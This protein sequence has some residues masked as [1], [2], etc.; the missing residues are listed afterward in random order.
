MPCYQGTVQFAFINHKA[1]L[2]STHIKPQKAKPFLVMS[3]LPFGR[4]LKHSRF[5]LTQKEAACYVA[6]LRKVYEGRIAPPPALSGGQL[7]L[8]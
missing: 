6:H 8:F 4:S 7:L 3:C 2:V 1:F 5:F